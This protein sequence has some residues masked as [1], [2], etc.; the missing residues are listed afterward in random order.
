VNK[1]ISRSVQNVPA[2]ADIDGEIYD[3][4][5]SVITF[6]GKRENIYELQQSD[7]ENYDDV[8]D[9]HQENSRLE[10]KPNCEAAPEKKCP[11]LPPRRFVP[12]VPQH[13][14][15][16]QI[17]VAKQ[18]SQYTNVVGVDGVGRKNIEIEGGTVSKWGL[19]RV[20]PIT[21]MEG[22]HERIQPNKG[23]EKGYTEV[24]PN[25]TTERGHREV[26]PNIGT[27]RGHT[28]VQ[29]IIVPVMT[30]ERPQQSVKHEM[31]Y[32]TEK[33]DEEGEEEIYDDICLN[34]ETPKAIKSPVLHEKHSITNGDIKNRAK[35]IEECLLKVGNQPKPKTS[36]QFQPN[37]ST[38]HK[39]KKNSGK[40]TLFCLA[41]TSTPNS[42]NQIQKPAS[43]MYEHNK[44]KE[45]ETT[46][47]SNTRLSSQPPELPPRSYLKK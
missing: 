37:T 47:P 1:S 39:A 27:E 38:L 13:D 5:G 3:D 2:P 16:D 26:Q 34:D 42:S 28:K 40:D 6:N 21:G 10:P 44:S 32:K 29:P 12:S 24:Q 4:A 43:N 8:L 17:S 35:M 14:L 11:P 25:T 19:T 20:L 15:S 23:T 36:N 45:K 41:Q 31:Q 7:E 33:K 22:G 30:K 18:G 9:T 46:I